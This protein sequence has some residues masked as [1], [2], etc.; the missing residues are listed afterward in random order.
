MG[1]PANEF[2]V[3]RFTSTEK[4]SRVVIDWTRPEILTVRIQLEAD[5]QG[6]LWRRDWTPDARFSQDAHKSL[7][8]PAL[9]LPREPGEN[10]LALIREG[11]LLEASWATKTES[12]VLAALRR[13]ILAV[14]RVTYLEAL[15]HLHRG[16]AK[17][18]DGNELEAIVEFRRGIAL[19]GS[20]YRAP[21]M[22]DDSEVRVGLA[23]FEERHGRWEKAAH[24]LETALEC[25]T[26]Q[27]AQRD[28]LPVERVRVPMGRP[29]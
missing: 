27:Y 8:D 26:M 11:K 17:H 18:S 23:D 24:F 14:A 4:D 5:P 10:S 28:E 6:T 12:E 3:T 16:H 13:T 7:S 9:P 25:R 1:S 15:A 21:H 19:F 29:G 20:S 2:M 22:L